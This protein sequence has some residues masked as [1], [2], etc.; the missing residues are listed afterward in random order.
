MKVLFVIIM[1]LVY[2][3]SVAQNEVLTVKDSLSVKLFDRGTRNVNKC[4]PWHH[5]QCVYIT[6]TEVYKDGSEGKSTRHWWRMSYIGRACTAQ[7]G[8]VFGQIFEGFFAI[9]HYIAIGAGNGIAYMVYL[10]RGSPE[11][12]QARK[13]KRSQRKLLRQA[14]R[15]KRGD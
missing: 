7:H 9:P 4:T 2:A 5:M 8:T 10:V 1:L 3:P 13:L 11:K 14:K 15:K 12:R 6:A